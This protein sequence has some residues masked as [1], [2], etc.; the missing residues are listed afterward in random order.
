MGGRVEEPSTLLAK[1]GEEKARRRCRPRVFSCTAE[2]GVALC[3]FLLVCLRAFLRVF[4]CVVD[5]IALPLS[6]PGSK[7][8]A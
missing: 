6:M 7:F 2:Y 5:G 3:L 8:A 1:K 4:F